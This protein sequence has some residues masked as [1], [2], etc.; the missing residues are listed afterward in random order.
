MTEAFFTHVIL[1]GGTAYYLVEGLFWRIEC[2]VA[3]GAQ[4][5]V[6]IYR[7][8]AKVLLK[9]RPEKIRKIRKFN[10]YDSALNA[11]FTL[12]SHHNKTEIKN[13]SKE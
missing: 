8:I 2:E 7:S 6:E 1:L 12:N 5:K 11:V 3:R 9:S 4:N 13:D 10:E